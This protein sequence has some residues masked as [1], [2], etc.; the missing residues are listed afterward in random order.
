MK[1]TEKTG[2]ALA[3]YAKRVCKVAT[4]EALKMVLERP[5]GSTPEGKRLL[6][7]KDVSMADIKQLRR[8][9]KA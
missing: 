5:L 3:T 2:Q 8:F 4:D 1:P 6:N 9:L 7:D